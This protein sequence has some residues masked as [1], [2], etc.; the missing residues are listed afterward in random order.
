VLPSPK[1]VEDGTYQPLSRPIFIYLSK[2]AAEK[3]EVKEF[4]EFY[5]QNAAKLV[6]QVK[7]VALPASAYT[8]GLEHFHKGK[9]GTV[10]DG[11]AQVGVK[12]EDLLK[13]EA[14]F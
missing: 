9:L 13:R 14:K 7:Y 6:K 4:V 1:T 5:L 10:F 3:P 12:I 11:E 8:L 2:K